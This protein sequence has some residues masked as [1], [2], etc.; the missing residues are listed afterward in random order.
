[1]PIS[2]Q[3]QDEARPGEPIP[4]EAELAGAKDPTGK[5]QPLLVDDSGNLLTASVPPP[6]TAEVYSGYIP[7][8]SSFDTGETNP[9]TEDA[10]DQLIT[11]GTILT[12]EGSFRDD[13]L[14]DLSTAL[15]GTLTFTNNSLE[16]TG[17]GT[18]FTTEIKAGQ[19]I[20]KSSDPESNQMTVSYIE[21]DTVLY[22]EEI[23]PGTTASTTAIISDWEQSTGTGASMS[24]V[25]SAVVIN[26]GT[27]STATTELA[28]HADYLPFNYKARC[29]ISQ[30]I[31][32]QTIRIGIF[33]QTSMPGKGC[34]FEFSGTD[35][36]KV[37]CV[38]QTADNADNRETQTITIPN[39]EISS[40]KQEYQIDLSGSNVAF[41]INNIIVAKMRNHIPG[42]YDLMEM[43]HY[44]INN[45]SVTNTSLEIHNVWFSNVDRIEIA[46]SFTGDPIPAQL[47]GTSSI[48]GLPVALALDQYGNLIVSPLGGLGANFSFGDV[49][50]TG[51]TKVPL[52]RTAYTEQTS[53]AQRSFASASANDTGAGTG[54]Q[55]IV[56]TYFTSTGSGPHTETITLAGTSTANTVAT[57]ICFV[58]KIQVSRVGSGG[59]NA[60]II[61]MYA[62]INKGGATIGT[63]GA[64]DNQTFWAHHYA[65][66]NKV[67]RISG[68][69]GSTD[70]T[71]SAYCLITISAKPIGVTGATEL[72][73]SDSVRIYG[74]ASET[75]RNYNSPISVQGPAK[76]TMY[77]Q[78]SSN[79]AQNTFGAFDFAES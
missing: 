79:A 20:R 45:G 40:N 57:D 43:A 9:L 67:C 17:S 49:G 68:I 36:T 5:I 46:S 47:Y 71:S 35:N 72:Q 21:S 13:F 77:A 52:R 34:W 75:V 1:M 66:K 2:Q 39:T 12:D 78:P 50:T 30:R 55:Q 64:G 19:Y 24:V 74:G 28:R 76:I 23:Y 59:V 48:T 61:T 69:S 51:T 41:S 6:V 73:V 31:A 3:E 25:S 29:A 44:L 32:N 16:I 38:S 7:D 33:G 22:L 4:I 37:L 70:N 27:N 42:P 10:S 54:A 53:N 18:A 26:S 14:S 8:P 65:A 62:A 58:E 63:I 11:R 15:T 60:G 56:L